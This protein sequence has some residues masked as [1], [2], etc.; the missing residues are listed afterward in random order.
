MEYPGYSINRTASPSEEAII[1][2]CNLLMEFVSSTL[3]VKPEK[4]VLIGR[5]IGSG[6]ACYLA[7]KHR[8]AA[9]V[10]ISAF[11]NIRDVVADLIGSWGSMLI[12]DRFNNLERIRKM[13]CPV[14]LIHGAKDSLVPPKH[15]EKLYGK[16]L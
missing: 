5:S 2:E 11:T 15:S 8:I 14:L 10:L 12:K 1:T 6:P 13:Q 3:F 16:I 7:E 4:I 9:L